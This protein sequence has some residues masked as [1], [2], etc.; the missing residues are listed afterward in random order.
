MDKLKHKANS[1]MNHENLH[2]SK[3]HNK[4]EGDSINRVLS[5]VTPQTTSV[6]SSSY[7][8]NSNDTPTHYTSARDIPHNNLNHDQANK[9]SS[10]MEFSN[11]DGNTTVGNLN[12]SI[13]DL[14]IHFP[15]LNGVEYFEKLSAFTMRYM[16]FGFLAQEEC[17]LIEKSSF[18]SPKSL[19]DNLRKNEAK[20]YQTKQYEG[21]DNCN[22][23][24]H[25]V[26]FLRGSC[27]P[28]TSLFVE[29][30]NRMSHRPL[31]VLNMD[32]SHLRQSYQI[33][34]NT[35]TES[36]NLDSQKGC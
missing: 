16:T 24:L 11:F 36:H 26:R 20:V 23:I 13:D 14:R 30:S 4:L 21:E 1:D 22:E 2:N 9:Q 29:A 15:N 3:M 28:S 27:A 5:S 6:A 18:N 8:N 25:E 34:T 12:M 19:E 7:S 31:P 33:A 17:K 35:Y 32:F 10:Q